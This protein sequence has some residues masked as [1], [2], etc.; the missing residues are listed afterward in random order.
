LAAKPILTMIAGPNG[1]GKSTLTKHLI[2][3][4]VDLGR[5]I[6]ADEI[7]AALPGP[8]G[9]ERSRRAQGLADEARREC[10][11]QGISFAFETVMSHPSK[12]EV[13]HEARRRGYFVV[14]FFVAL[15][16][17]RLNVER[18]RQRVALGGHPVPEDRIVARY[19]RTMALLPEAL[20]VCDRAVL[21]DNSYR[22]RAGERVALVPVAEFQERRK[23]EAWSPRWLDGEGGPLILDR[24][25]RWAQTALRQLGGPPE[26]Y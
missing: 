15:E 19:D 21:F 13:L 9:E 7:D 20:T 23:G 17:P 1:S 6:N 22:K 16:H 12:I 24:L 10:L 14:I 3:R 18:V 4:G 11:E 8:P 5:Y 2:A 25:P 26:Y